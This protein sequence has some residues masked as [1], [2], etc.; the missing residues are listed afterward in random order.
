MRQSQSLVLN[1]SSNDQRPQALKN[2]PQNDAEPVVIQDGSP[3]ES[4]MGEG[5]S[6]GMG[7]IAFTDEQNSAFFGNL[8]K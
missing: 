3:Q 2:T 8:T 7:A 4:Q 1:P 5:P 6:D